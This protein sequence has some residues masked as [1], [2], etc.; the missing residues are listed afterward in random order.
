MLMNKKVNTALPDQE[1]LRR[2]VMISLFTWRRA[3]PDDDTDTPF[4]WWGDTW[5]TVQNDRIGSRL[6]LLKRSTLTNQTAQ[7]AKEYIAQAL[8]WMTDDGIALRV[9]IEV[10]RSG[11]DRLIATVI[12]MLPDHNI[13]TMTI[14]NLWRVIHAN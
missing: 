14:N 5:P 12:L 1:R 6:H 7:K 8:T 11:I 9:D 10:V 3:E 4:G 2:A 13:K